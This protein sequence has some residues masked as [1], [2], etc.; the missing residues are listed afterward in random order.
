MENFVFVITVFS[1]VFSDVEVLF[2]ATGDVFLL[3]SL[4]FKVDDEVESK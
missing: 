1:P 3:V 4:L 2:S